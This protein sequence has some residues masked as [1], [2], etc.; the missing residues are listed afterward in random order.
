MFPGF[1]ESK[2]AGLASTFD[3]LI[4]LRDKLG[5]MDP[6]GELDVWGDSTGS[7]IPRDLGDLWRRI[8]EAWGDGRGRMDCGSALK[9]KGKEK[10]C[11]VFADR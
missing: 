10:L 9:P 5:G 8:N 2:K 11:V 3:Q 7:G 1:I 4:G 6:S